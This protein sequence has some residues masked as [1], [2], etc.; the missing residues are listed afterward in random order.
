MKKCINKMLNLQGLL[1]D[2]LEVLDE[3][4]LVLVNCRNPRLKVKCPLCNKSTDKVH[5]YKKRKVNHGIL[6]Y[7]KMICPDYT[8][9]VGVWES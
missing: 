2:K 9:P 7:R 6:N 8:E 1:V 4:K 3:E 5:S